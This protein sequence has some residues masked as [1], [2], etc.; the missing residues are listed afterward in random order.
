MKTK[1]LYFALLLIG[2]SANAQIQRNYK[3]SYIDSIT[4]SVF[5]TLSYGVDVLPLSANLTDF[6]LKKSDSKRYN[7]FMLNSL[8]T[9]LLNEKAFSSS[10]LS[11][12]KYFA[13][14][15]NEDNEFSFGMNFNTK[16]SNLIKRT[17]I[18][19]A[20]FTLKSNSGFATVFKN[21]ALQND[22]YL[23]G[24][25]GHIGKGVITFTGSD[26]TAYNNYYKNYLKDTYRKKMA[27]T[28]AIGESIDEELKKLTAASEDKSTSFEAEL[29]KTKKDLIS[30]IAEDEMKALEEYRW[31]KRVRVF[32][33]SADVKLPVST[34]EFKTALSNDSISI[35]KENQYLWNVSTQGTFV[36]KNRKKSKL[37]LTG[38]V[39]FEHSNNAITEDLSTSNFLTFV[40]Q[41]ANNL[42][43]ANTD[44]V[45]IGEFNR[46]TVGTIGA[47][48]IFFFRDCK[49]GLSGSIEQT[50]IGTDFTNWKVGVPIKLRDKDQKGVNLEL[51]WKEV[52][53]THLVGFRA[54][55]VLGKFVK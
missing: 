40:S 49:F 23:T 42:A 33:W 20:G 45:Y 35:I 39:S 11:T 8:F 44:K 26:K 27:K 43:V 51:Q 38:R 46:F 1:I 50:F 14:L 47:E 54:G 41:G 30:K 37:F 55:F 12:S 21:G 15:T 28:L 10:D 32:F 48:G 52:N 7:G 25:F 13:S 22:I 36:W 17:W 19:S 53:K 9:S 31:Y 16:K 2:T 4:N 29:N 34:N 6:Q 24:K 5:D 3:Q 18:G